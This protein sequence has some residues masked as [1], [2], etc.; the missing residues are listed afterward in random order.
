MKIQW[1]GHACFLLTSND[2]IRILMD[3]FDESVGYDLPNTSADI[4]TV[5]H[6]HSDHSN[7]ALVDGP[8]DL[9]DTP[10][11]HFIKGMNIKGIPTYHDNSQGAKR[12]TNIIFNV[13][14]DNLNVC[15][16]GDLGHM[17]TSEQISALGAVDILLIPVGGTYTIDAIIARDII[18]ALKP[19]L[20]IPMHY[21]TEILTFTIDGVQPFLDLTNG[22]AI[23]HKEIEISTKN[24]ANYEDYHGVVALTYK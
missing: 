15:H 8:F 20:T 24:G 13:S 1:F 21:K 2:N 22:H 4:V 3:P 16:C 7:T 19:R 23:C 12:G 6:Q 17:L 11:K 14:V 5:S 10:G 9:V 18:D